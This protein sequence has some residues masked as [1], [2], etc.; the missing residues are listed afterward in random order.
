MRTI[1]L[2]TTKRCDVLHMTCNAVMRDGVARCNV[3]M[4]VV[5]D[6]VLICGKE[7]QY[8][9]CDSM[10]FKVEFAM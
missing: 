4:S 9:A 8:N 5:T 1:K 10:G 7:L 3:V 2:K 6:K